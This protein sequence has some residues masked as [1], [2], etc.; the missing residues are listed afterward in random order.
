[1][2]TTLMTEFGV[3]KSV[4]LVPNGSEIPVTAE[5]RHEC[6]FDMD[7]LIPQISNWCASTSW[8][9]RFKLRVGLSSVVSL[10]SSIR[11]VS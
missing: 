6:G 11:S 3:V 1:V 2:S 4:D 5:N 10:I 8:I 7:E 9:P